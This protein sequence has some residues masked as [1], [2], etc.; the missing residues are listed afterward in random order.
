MRHSGI[1]FTAAA[2]MLLTSPA[3]F[4][5]GNTAQGRAIVTV[6]PSKSGEQGVVVSPRDVKMLKFNGKNAD[7]ISMSAASNR[8]VELVIL[9]DSD[10]RN[11]IGTQM[12]DF[13]SFAKELP[14]NTKM[15]F[16]YMIN[17]RAVFTGP[18][19]SDPQQILKE[20]RLP[21]GPIGM[22]ASPY[23]CLS[24]LARNWPSR[25]PNARREV[26]MIG[27]G[28]DDYYVHYDPEDPYVLAAIQDSIRSGLIVYAIYWK[29][30]GRLDRFG[31]AQMDGQNLL[32]EVTEATGGYSFWN[33]FGNPVSFS[34]YFNEMR[35]RLANQYDLDFTAPFDGKPQV[36]SLR[37]KLQVPGA[38]VDAPEQVF[39]YPASQA[40]GH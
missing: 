14:A 20:L 19:S 8:P 24:D 33:G 34:P 40:Q 28:I 12:G 7:V 27:D 9:T 37:L 32:A 2:V 15:A 6:L 17:G 26:I 16:A 13:T 38:K 39:V 5:Q 21:G 1:L 35:R 4:A 11:T 29:D 3:S 25:T 22:E 30:Q 10:T 31:W 18:L 23:F 36:G